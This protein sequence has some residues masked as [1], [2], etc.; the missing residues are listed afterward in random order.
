MNFLIHLYVA[1]QNK[2]SLIG[3]FL[4]DF[5]KGSNLQRFNQ[6]IQAAIRCHRKI[7]TFSDHHDATRRSRRRISKIRR[8]FAGVIVDVC[9]DHFLAR[10]WNRYKQCSLQSFTRKVYKELQ[11][12]RPLLNTHEQLVL[13]RMIDYDWLGSYYH[14]ENVGIAL[15]RISTRLSRGDAF[16]GSICDVESNYKGLERDFNAFFPD[17][18]YFSKSEMDSN[19]E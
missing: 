8:R 3:H 4:G 7:D 1:D 17:L 13:D 18:I 14:L 12:H 9:Y 5:V 19:S 15:D 11:Q 2:D 10:N 16:L 6:Q